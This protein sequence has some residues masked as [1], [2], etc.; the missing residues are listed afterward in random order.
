MFELLFKYPRAVFAKGTLVLL[1]SWPWWVF[2]LAL[3]AAGAGLG[4]LIRS[5]LPQASAHVKN[6]RAGVIWLLQFALAALV[7]FLL[8]QPA[9]LVAELRPQQNII[10]VLV[11]DSR[12]MS[13]TDA[14]GGATREAQAIKA[15]E[16]GV[17]DGLQ[18]KFQVRVYRIDR[19]I[20]RVPKLDDLKT[21]PPAS[22]TRIGDGLKQLAG[23]AADLPIGAVVLL[24]DGADNA[25]GIDL[26]TISTFR[27]R[28]IPVHTV[29]FGAEQVPQDVEITDAAVVPRALADSRLSAKVTLHQ[30]G[31]AGQKAMLTVRDGGKVLAGR[32]I[33]LA[34]DGATQNEA[35]QFNAGDAG[36]KTLQFSI[37]PLP[38]EENPNNNSVARLVNVESGRKRILYVEGEPRWEYKFIRRAEQD[39]RLLTIV[40]ML[41]TSE[42]KIYRQGIED[43][44][45]LADGFPSRAEDLFP[46]QGLIIGSVEAS[47]FTAAQKELIQQFVD[48]RGGGLLFLGGRAALGDGGWASASLADLL[49]VTLPNKKNTF[50]RDA[51]TVSLTAAGADSIITRLVEEPA[52][53]VERWKK[54]PYLMDY[55]EVGTPKPGAVVL[56]EMTAAG[57]K[58][59]MLITE[60]YG[61]GRTAI[62]ATG[63]TWRWQMSQPLEDQTHEEFWQQ[64]LRWLVT[65]TPGRIVATIPSQTLFDD[66][67]VQLSADV[68]DKNYVPASDAHVE[69]HILGPGGSAAQIEMTPDPNT[70]GVFHAEW[71][72]DQPGTYLTEVIAA[73]DKD[74]LGR[75]VLSFAR[76]DGVAEN[77][78]TAQNRDLLEKLSAETGGQYWTPQDVSRLPSEISYSE[79]GITVRDTK[80]LW[81]MPI[82]FLLLVALP[83]L[84][85]LLRRRWGVV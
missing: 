78:H 19:Q 67:H 27:S 59:P 36:A 4:W 72:A 55:Q 75:D 18:K 54:L 63:G 42:N 38:G 60:N 22:A 52:A 32:Q 45:E 12:S 10:A 62:N 40:S 37:D 11:D 3:L 58:M 85:W 48:R 25:G 7:L 66:G 6:W 2:V 23:E 49:P 84:E 61:R 21:A 44:K 20:S 71:T 74:E 34:A 29:G 64:L 33:T 76:M 80:E 24:S 43:P 30:R 46:Y 50:H 17:L 5:K 26:D 69:A 56:A 57:R 82:V 8:W 14:G 1:G 47:Y 70:A 39:D 73:R 13:I 41:R 68:R 53:N 83:S 28:R 51:A 65:D 31:Y 81:N 35:L 77:F 15:L 79:A 16:G 9:I